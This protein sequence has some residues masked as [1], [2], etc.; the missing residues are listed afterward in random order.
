MIAHCG[1]PIVW[2]TFIGKYDQTRM[3][4]RSSNCSK[5]LDVLSTGCLFAC[6]NQLKCLVLSSLQGCPV[7]RHVSDCPDA[8]VQNSSKQILQVLVRVDDKSISHWHGL[9]IASKFL[10]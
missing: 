6:D 5:Q 7:G 8:G 1:K 9:H 4:A 10:E 2:S 3:R